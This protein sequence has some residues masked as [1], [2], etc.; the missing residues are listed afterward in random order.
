MRRPRAEGGPNAVRAAVTA[1]GLLAALLVSAP[2]A[3][4]AELPKER[5][6]ADGA[7]M[8]LVPAGEFVMGAPEGVGEADERPEHRVR[9][10]AFYLDKYEVTVARYDKFLEAT[11]WMRPVNW[12]QLELSEVG[13]RPVVGVSWNDAQK[14][15][16]WADR[17]LPTEAEWE[18][19]ARGTDGRRYP[20]GDAEP[21]A[22]LAN[23]ART[24]SYDY[25]KKRLEAVGSRE[26]S[27]SPFG[28]YEMA[29]NVWEWVADWYDAKY[30]AR[31]PEK[32]PPGPESGTLKVLR[33]GSWN[34]STQY[35]RATV[36]LKYEPTAREADVGFRCAQDANPRK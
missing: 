15:C 24:W 4:E 19:A 23:Y 13:D 29:G 21:D 2:S 5:A 6:G 14:Y 30:Y 31:S 12:Y 27:K 33:G 16:E 17:R 25:Y 34:F 18:Y 8:V 10:D 36:R 28:V 7:P 11:G 1:G 9:I 3:A 32:N 26:A 20:W 22:K 35:L